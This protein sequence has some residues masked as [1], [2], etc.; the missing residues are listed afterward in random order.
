[1]TVRTSATR[2]SSRPPVSGTTARASEGST[3]R[4]NLAAAW[5]ALGAV[6]CVLERRL[7]LDGE[8]SVLVARTAA[9]DH[10]VYPVTE[11]VHVEASST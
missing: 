1:M 10:A 9:G 6:P 8:L 11:N 5:A 3:A 7:P 2:R 4:T